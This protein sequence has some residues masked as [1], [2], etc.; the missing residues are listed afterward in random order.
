MSLENRFIVRTVTIT[1]VC[2]QVSIIISIIDVML[3]TETEHAGHVSTP[4]VI[5]LTQS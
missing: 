2:A 3:V 4:I 5:A 1:R